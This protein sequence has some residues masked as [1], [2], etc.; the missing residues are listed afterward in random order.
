MK[1]IKGSMNEG[2]FLVP[3]RV[4][5]DADK[6]IVCVSGVQQTMAIWRSFVLHF[7][8][9]YRVVVFDAPG[10]G[11]ARIVSGPPAISLDEQIGVLHKIISATEGDDELIL[12]AASWGTIVAAGFAARYP[13]KVS[14]LVLGSFGVKPNKKLLDL[15]KEGQSLH[16]ASNGYQI[17]QLIIDNFGQ[18]LNNDYK[19][20][21]VE[22][23]R[24][25][26]DEQF[27]SF[28]A[29]SELIE[30]ARDIS[31]HINL[32][33]IKAKTLIING[34]YD[35][36]IDLEDAETAATRIP[37]CEFRIVTGA[38]HFLHHENGCEDIFQIYEEFFCR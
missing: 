21:I 3:Y 30:N 15:I 6:R 28:Y 16:E 34:E 33:N 36:I 11:Q 8:P 14:K 12:G 5:G 29:M 23:F 22:Q 25:I 31:D 7:A 24:H 9:R 35:E 2:R 10:Q 32:Q 37:D 1:K 26:D 38:G 18:R 20:R 4:Y 27:W 19:N 13:E 17:A